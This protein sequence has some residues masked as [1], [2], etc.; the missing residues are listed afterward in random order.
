LSRIEKS[1]LFS[2]FRCVSLER[3]WNAIRTVLEKERIN[4]ASTDRADGRITTD[5]VP[6]ASQ[7]G[8][9]GGSLTTRYKYNL[10]LRRTDKATTKVGITSTLESSS[11]N[12]PWHDISKDN[13]ERVTKLE[14]WLY[15]RIEQAL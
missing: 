11:K 2:L 8:L 7:V 3:L 10:S 13:E 1:S 4:I 5:Y 9:I 12:I 6:G 15:E 14:N